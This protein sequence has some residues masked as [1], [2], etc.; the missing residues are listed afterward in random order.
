MEFEQNE[1]LVRFGAFF[2]L[3]LLLYAAQRRWPARGDGRPARRQLVNFGMVAVSTGV[4]RVGFPVLAV[5]WA[6][7]V[8]G[9]G[10]FGLLAWPAWLE[11][12]AAILLLDVA[13]YWQH[14]LMHTVPLLWRLHRVHHCDTAFDV[15][16][17]VRFHPL[18]IALSMG[19]KL[20]LISL[21]GP[22]PVA[23][24]AFEVLLSLGS[25]FTHT[26][27]ALPRALDRR[28]RWVFVTPSMHRIHHSTRR[29][30]TDSN[31]GFHLS[32]WDRVFRSYTVEPA[33]DER[34]MPIGLEQW[35]EPRDQGLVSLLLNP[36]RP[37]PRAA[38]ADAPADGEP[39]A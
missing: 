8:H 6:A 3:L 29:V 37:T 30:E 5:A 11:I 27:I 12:A 4:L 31:Y 14:R 35:R 32:V 1:A 21:L 39:H 17:G 26:D 7:Q 25:L 36:F 22:H 24:L 13:I 18:E 2:G 23:V 34:R 33:E 16:T 38:R 10:L 15:T 9:G 20:A 28:L 19:F